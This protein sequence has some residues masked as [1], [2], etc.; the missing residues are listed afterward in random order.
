MTEKITLNRQASGG[1]SVERG[2]VSPAPKP[3]TEDRKT[4]QYAFEREEVVY[5]DHLEDFL[6]YLLQKM[7][8]NTNLEPCLPPHLSFVAVPWLNSVMISIFTIISRP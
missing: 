4:Q 6:L 1:K 2:V 3:K 8:R 5:Y 7:G